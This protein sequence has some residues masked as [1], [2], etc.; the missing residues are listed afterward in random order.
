MDSKE[1]IYCRI[2]KEQAKSISILLEAEIGVEWNED[3]GVYEIKEHYFD[4]EKIKQIIC[5]KC[6]HSLIKE[7][8]LFS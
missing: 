6:S 3:D 2:C 5:C 1:K 8:S 7:Q 4:F